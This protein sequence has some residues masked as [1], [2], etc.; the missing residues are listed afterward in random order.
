MRDDVDVFNIALT[1]ILTRQAQYIAP[2]LYSGSVD[3]RDT[4]VASAVNNSNQAS[5]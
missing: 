3:S 5:E 1:T 4:W 2:M